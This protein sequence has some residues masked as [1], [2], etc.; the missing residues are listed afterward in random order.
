M[1]GD[2]P[3][4]RTELPTDTPGVT[5]SSHNKTNMSFN[6]SLNIKIFRYLRI[7]I[8]EI[9]SFPSEI[10]SSFPQ[11]NPFSIFPILLLLRFAFILSTSFLSEDFSSQKASNP[12]TCLPLF[13]P[14]RITI[15]R[16][17]RAFFLE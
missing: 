12:S 5:L 6:F 8:F 7:S 10:P 9:I 15:L 11:E 14:S 16:G 17:F 1:S 2:N 3:Q 4:I 13:K